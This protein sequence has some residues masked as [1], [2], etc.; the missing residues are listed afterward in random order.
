M[1]S[2]IW[3]V[4]TDRKSGI[5]PS[6]YT[7]QGNEHT[8]TEYV[9]VSTVNRGVEAGAASIYAAPEVK[10]I[11]ASL[12][13]YFGDAWKGGQNLYDAVIDTIEAR[14]GASERERWYGRG[15][16]SA[17]E[18]VKNNFPVTDIEDMTDLLAELEAVRDHAT[19]AEV[20]GYAKATADSIER[21]AG[22]G[23]GK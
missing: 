1:P 3:L 23:E 14:T 7:E 15:I 16:R 19:E 11:A 5:D 10:E 17:I 13:A 4:V 9:L 2:S 22:G 8:D 6:W 12:A 20:R 21:A 18:I